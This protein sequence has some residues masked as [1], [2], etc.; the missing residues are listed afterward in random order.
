MNLDTL[1]QLGFTVTGEGSEARVTA[2]LMSPLMNPLSRRFIEKVQFRQVD[3]RLAPIDP[4]ELVGISP[5]PVA[6][7]E[8]FSEFEAQL[9]AEFDR[10]VLQ[11]QRRSAE[12]QALGIQP[13]VDPSSLVLSA[14]VQTPVLSLQVEADRQGN[15]RVVSARR[16]EQALSIPA[17][18]RF[19][20]GEFRESSALLGYL[21]T[22]VLELSGLKDVQGPPAA[23]M[24]AGIVRPL[25]FGEL[26]ER[27]GRRAVIPQ[28]TAVEIVTDLRVDGE[29][30]RFAASRVVGRTFR[31]LLAG[32]RGKVWADRFELDDFAGVPALAA[33]QLGVEE[34]AVELLGLDLPG[35]K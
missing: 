5:Q 11:M 10:S 31:G 29:R 33:Q 30:Y 1:V 8:R 34:S 12:L 4:P 9:R 15:F 19:E 2:E 28:K 21:Q 35:A 20:L 14:Q 26:A 3:N 17:N 32:P 25:N 7:L 27:F 22:L 16:G 18:T 13:E 24:P 6:G 23:V